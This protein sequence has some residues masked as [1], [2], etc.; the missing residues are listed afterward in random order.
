[1]SRKKCEKSLQSK[2]VENM[3]AKGEIAQNNEQLLFL[4]QW[5]SKSFAAVA[6]ESVCKWET[7]NYCIVNLFS[8]YLLWVLTVTESMTFDRKMKNIVGMREIA[9]VEHFFISCSVSNVFYIGGNWIAWKDKP[10][11]GVYPVYM[12]MDC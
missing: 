9:H 7:V 10:N 11:V 4:P 5:F 3:M 2:G 1:M 8:E 12:L 6:S